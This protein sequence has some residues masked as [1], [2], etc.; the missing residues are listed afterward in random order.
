MVDGL[1]DTIDPVL[2]HLIAV[3]IKI[4]VEKSFGC[5]ETTVGLAET[6]VMRDKLIK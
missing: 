4:D 1:Y 2:S 5:F 3:K 6:M